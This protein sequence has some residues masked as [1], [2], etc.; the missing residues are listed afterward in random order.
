MVA[1][2][3]GAILLAVGYQASGLALVVPTGAYLAAASRELVGRRE[4]LTAQQKYIHFGLEVAADAGII[5]GLLALA[6]VRQTGLAWQAFGVISAGV[7]VGLWWSHRKFYSDP[8]VD[9]APK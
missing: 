3:M 6:L 7:L 1:L 4:R 2:L 8:L 5:L 9:D